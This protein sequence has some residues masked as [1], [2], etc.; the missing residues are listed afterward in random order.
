M[1]A[2]YAVKDL[3]RAEQEFKRKPGMGRW[4]TIQELLDAG[5]VDRNLTSGVRDGYRFDLRISGE[6]YQITA[7]PVTPPNDKLAFLGTAYF[8]DESGII[9]GRA[10]GKDSSYALPGKEDAVVKD[11]G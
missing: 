1:K 6:S 4:G 8:A 7:V 5:I 11:L 2:Y 3:I 10:Y 9:R